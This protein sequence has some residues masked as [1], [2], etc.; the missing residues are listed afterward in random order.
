MNNNYFFDLPFEIQL[1]ILDLIP[2]F[3]NVEQRSIEFTY[4]Y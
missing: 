3:R 4:R 2:R 1:Y